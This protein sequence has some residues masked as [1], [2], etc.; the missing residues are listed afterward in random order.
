MKTRNRLR[1]ATR[2]PLRKELK[3]KRMRMITKS[4]KKVS[5]MQLFKRNLTSNGTMSL[6]SS[7]PK[8]V[9]KKQ[10]LCLLSSQNCFRV[11]ES[12][13]KVFYF[14]D[15]QVQVRVSL[16]KLVQPSAIAHSF[17]FLLQIWLASGRVSLKSLLKTCSKWLEI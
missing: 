7:L 1:T 13:G 4:C 14:M 6:D 16:L 12:H 11:A 15:H 2:P 9:S 5:V 3:K 17:Q 8:K 10:S